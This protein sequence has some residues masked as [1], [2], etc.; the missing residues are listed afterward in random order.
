MLSSDEM[1]AWQQSIESETASKVGL[2]SLAN[3]TSLN[4]ATTGAGGEPL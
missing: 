1:R 2:G 3:A 4:E